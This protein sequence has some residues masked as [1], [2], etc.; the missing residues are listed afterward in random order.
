MGSTRRSLTE[1]GVADG[2]PAPPRRIP[3]IQV[4]PA[5]P[6]PLTGAR[7]QT[8]DLAQRGG[9]LGHHRDAARQADNN[10]SGPARGVVGQEH[11]AT[12]GAARRIDLGV[13]GAH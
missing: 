5:Q 3:I 6:R 8:S 4:L 10:K 13:R 1:C 11:P 9:T 7:S 12:V 2:M